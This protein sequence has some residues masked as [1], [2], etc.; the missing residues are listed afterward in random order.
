MNAQ[1]EGEVPATNKAPLVSEYVRGDSR[2][3]HLSVRSLIAMMVLFTLCVIVVVIAVRVKDVELVVPALK[4][5]FIPTVT[6]V[7][8]FYFATK[9]PNKGGVP[10]S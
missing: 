5:L 1:P 6:A 9:S 8:I 7:V 4:E 10:P 2:V 3:A